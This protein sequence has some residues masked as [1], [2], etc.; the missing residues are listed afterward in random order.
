M[1]E[2]AMVMDYLFIRLLFSLFFWYEIDKGLS[3]T[4]N[5]I[6]KSPINH[7]KYYFKIIHLLL[8]FLFY[9]HRFLFLIFFATMFS[10]LFLYKAKIIAYT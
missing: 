5:A 2:I 1:F 3:K 8:F 4:I 6:L 9:I 7:N 10:L